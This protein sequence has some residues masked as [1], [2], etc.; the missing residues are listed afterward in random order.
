MSLKHDNYKLQLR[1]ARIVLETEF[2]SKHREKSK[3]KKKITNTGEQLK[4]ALG[5]ILCNTLIH[6]INK[7][8]GSRRTAILFHHKK[9]LEKFHERQHK[10]KG[11][12]EEKLKRHIIHTFSSYVLSHEECLA[13]S[14]GLDT[15]IPRNINTNKTCTEFICFTK[16]YCKTF[17]IFL[18][19]NYKKSKENN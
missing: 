19:Q 8:I 1:I 3:L 14:F 15:H 9:K 2:R 4:N 16:T 10:P 12:N 13:L 11:Q 5:L 6:Q 7:V 17:P 18:R